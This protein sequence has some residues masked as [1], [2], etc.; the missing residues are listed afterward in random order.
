[1][2]RR[3]VFRSTTDLRDRI[4]TFIDY[5]NDTMAKPFKWTYAS[6]PLNV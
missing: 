2:L 5:Y 4:L 6:R 3:G 1:M